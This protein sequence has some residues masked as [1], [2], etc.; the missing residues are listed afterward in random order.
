MNTIMHSKPYSSEIKDRGIGLLLVWPQ[1]LS[2]PDHDYFYQIASAPAMRAPA[3]ETHLG[4]SCRN[5]HNTCTVTS[6]D[7]PAL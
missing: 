3:R 1:L 7:K 6:L 2:P 4:T 5:R